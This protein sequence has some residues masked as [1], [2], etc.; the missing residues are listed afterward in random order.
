MGQRR[1]PE[2]T[3][4]SVRSDNEGDTLSAED[5]HLVRRAS[6]R[7]PSWPPHPD[8][9]RSV[10]PFDV[11]LAMPPRHRTLKPVRV[12]TS[13][14]VG[15]CLLLSHSP[16]ALGQD[17]E[18]LH[19]RYTITTWS[20]RDG[21]PEGSIVAVAQDSSGFLW[22]GSG[23]GLVR[24]DGVSFEVV[25]DLPQEAVRALCGAR[26]GSLWVG[27]GQGSQI[28]R[29]QGGDRR[30]YGP[31]DGVGTGV[32][33]GIVEDGAGTIWAGD[34]TGLSRLLGDRFV[35]VSQAEGLPPA[36]VT[37]LTV[38]S[39]GNLLVGTRQGVFRMSADRRSFVRLDDFDDDGRGVQGLAEDRHGRVWMADGRHGLRQLESGPVVLGPGQARGIRVLVDRRGAVWVSTTGAGVWRLDPQEGRDGAK[40]GRAPISGGRAMYEDGEGNIWI[41]TIEGLVRLSERR[42]REIPSLGTVFGIEA[43][44]DGSVWVASADELVRF[45]KVGERWQ[46]DE[47]SW[48]DA[49]V[50][51]M[52]ASRDGTLWVVDATGL[53][54][55][56]EGRTRRVA[57]P[58]GLAE[59]AVEA[60][61]TSPDG[62]TIW[63]AT[64]HAGLLRWHLDAE[65]PIQPIAALASTRFRSVVADSQ[66]RVWFTSLA[67][68]LGLLDPSNTVRWFDT[69]D[70]LGVSTSYALYED[71]DDIWV[72]GMD[73]LRRYTG[74]R[75]VAVVPAHHDRW[76]VPTLVRD[77]EGD[78]WL[79]TNYGI[80]W[81]TR[82]EMDAWKRD[83]THRVH[84]RLF[85]TADGLSGRPGMW[86]GR[87]SALSA[88]GQI[89]VVTGRGLALL[90]PSQL[91]QSRPPAAVWIDRVRVG[92]RP[93][94]LNTAG[95]VRTRSDQVVIDYGALELT[96]PDKVRFRY[97]LD[98]LD[99]DWVEAGARRQV[100]YDRLPARRYRF[101]VSA[102][103]MEG[104]WTEPEAVWEFTVVPPVHQTTWFAALCGLAVLAAVWAFWLLRLRR[105]RLQFA[106]LLG[107]RV[108]LSR[109]LH[110]TLL[111][112]LVGV[113]LQLEAASNSLDADSPA[114]PRL[115]AIR[116]RVEDYIREARLSI[117]N[118]R[119]HKPETHDLIAQLKDTAERVSAATVPVD[120]IVNG[121]PRH[122]EPM[123]ETHLLHIGQEAVLNAA[124]HA[125]ATR[126]LIELEYADEALTLRVSDDGCGFDTSKWVA[127]GSS[128]LGLVSMRERA[129]QVGAR[130]TLSSGV[131]GGT[132]VEVVASVSAVVEVRA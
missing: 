124:R 4:R 55:V 107:E 7:V 11:C 49:P 30:L 10:P 59:D 131:G 26:D 79:G 20:S 52:H 5:L 68:R 41:G 98:G 87:T 108:R 1:C 121:K 38:D 19:D 60:L 93:V 15:C 90:A 114:R 39:S 28:A 86:G 43:T 81:L 51:A 92:G 29:V 6:Y 132:V 18:E 53:R 125:G 12:R 24:F 34:T 54:Q 40:I 100:V 129:E 80:A 13:L 115:L 3:R 94:S 70:G 78:F 61:T 21:L 22:L 25:R 130:F 23:E 9:S 113:A 120:L 16:A 105:S 116:R 96:T 57:M 33:S 50:R 122:L 106:A 46:R 82:D 62:R 95:P 69:T 77:A 63:M 119:S 110:D 103:H 123:V 76:A 66:G 88:D 32:L 31:A 65:P 58:G 126:V 37:S 48:A 47:R 14:A 83:P 71:E 104:A 127:D 101:R 128:H 85:D 111:Q 112:S 117:W 109:E 72:A 118:L 91:R 44:P 89:W 64:R 75:F 97:R 42:I 99:A 73:G 45:H 17:F 2:C 35:R 74:G 56:R 84:Y 102:S 8:M 27:F 36:S 67:G